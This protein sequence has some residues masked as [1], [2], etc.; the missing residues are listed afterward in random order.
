MTKF[1]HKIDSSTN[2]I[3]FIY[4]GT[5]ETHLGRLLWGGVP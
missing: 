5:Y 1:E 2:L 4:Q 3:S